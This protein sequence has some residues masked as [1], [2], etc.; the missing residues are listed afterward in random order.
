MANE[1]SYAAFLSTGGRV[2][3]ILSDRLHELL[4]DP[5]SLRALMT[6]LPRTGPGSA[7]LNT[8]RVQRGMVLAAASS[9]ISGGFTNQIPTTTNFDC[10]VARYGGVMQPTDLLKITGG[11]IDM[12]YLLGILIET[13]DLTLTDLLVALFANIAGNVGTSGSD[14]TT[15]DFFDAI[16]YLN[17]QNNPGQGT[18][19]VLHN[20]QINDLIESARGETGPMQFRTDAQGLLQPAGVGFRGQFAGVALVQCDSVVSTGADRRGCMFT[21]GAFAYQL[22]SVSGMMDGQMINPADILF[23]TDEMFIERARDAAN[24]MSSAFVNCYPGT[25]EQEDLR[26]VRITTDA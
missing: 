20:Q 8:P 21:A 14:L 5:V 9:E 19:A 10:T 22:A 12:D 18:V 16:Y 11:P 13:L 15:D 25:A 6:M 24:A 2:A 17:L 4:Y 26:A 7:T 23:G 3:R 1:S